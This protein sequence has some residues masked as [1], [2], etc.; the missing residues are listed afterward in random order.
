V[1]YLKSDGTKGSVSSGQLDGNQLIIYSTSQ[2][3][4]LTT[5]IYENISLIQNSALQTLTF[6]NTVASSPSSEPE[7][8]DQIRTNA[9]KI[10]QT[11]NRVVTSQDIE[12][13][14]SKN[15]SNIV[16]SVKAVSSKSYIDNVIKYFY[17][18]GLDRPNDDGRVLFNEV[19]FAT[20]GQANDVY[21][22]LSPKIIATD[23]SNNMYF[24]SQSQKSEILS[25]I[26]KIKMINMNII[27]QDPVYNAITVGI[28][29]PGDEVTVS[30]GDSTALV[31]QR[32]SNSK[33]NSQKVIELT[34]NIFTDYFS[35][36]NS[37]LGKLIDINYIQSQ[38]LQIPG[39]TNI[40]TRK[41][42]N[43]RVYEVPFINLL[44]Y[45][46]TYSYADIQS[47]STNIQLPYF[48]FPFLLNGS[49]SDKIIIETINA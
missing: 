32:S 41:S 34:N 19:K 28:Q 31:I 13:Y 4:R 11:Q 22:Y 9:P 20:T 7:S 40:K 47:T 45:N 39:V 38:I 1:Y 12:S 43:G 33:I 18:I 8:V 25:N 6:V 35:A 37:T 21:V 44:S 49:I 15:F 27:P 30:D 24:L 10:L 46:Y 26:D 17:N 36:V 2:F 5:K 14:I 3:D 48:K 42:V 16:S 29:F 23:S